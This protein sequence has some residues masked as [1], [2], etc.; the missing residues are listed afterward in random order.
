MKRKGI[1]LAGGTGSR[2]YPMTAGVSKQLLPIYDKPMVYYP[3]TTL[4]LAGIREI[5]L[6]STP[7]EKNRYEKVLGNGSLWGISIKYAIQNKPSGLAEAFV[8]GAD[9]IDNGPSALILGD[10]LFYGSQLVKQLES[11]NN[12]SIGATIFAYSVVDPQRYGVVEFDHNQ[13]AINIQEKPNIPKSN[14]AI[15]GLYF[16]DRSVI[17]KAQKVKPSSRGELEISDINL[18]YL[19]E[20]NL[21]VELLGRGMAWLDTG[22]VD[23]LHDA[24]SFIKTIENRQ[25]LKVG[26]PEEV[27]WRKGWISKSE[28]KSL[29]ERSLNS[30]YGK[31]LLQLLCN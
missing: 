21:K 17:E 23:S 5:L 3:L 22:T 28:L 18:M 19:A 24:S 25:G 13:R 1:I 8:I 31:Y 2:L 10:N 30:G 15:T 27:A 16:Y 14:F 9:F 29:G 7:E 26:C 11:A 4:M 6:I 12:Q 20:E